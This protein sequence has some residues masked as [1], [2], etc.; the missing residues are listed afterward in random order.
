M[1]TALVAI[2]VVV[3][4]GLVACGGNGEAGKP[5]TLEQRLIREP[6]APGSREDPV[7][8]RLTAAN[9]DEFTAWQNEGYV[10]AAE[11][12][13]GKLKKAG[14]VAAIHDT[15]FFPKTLGGPHTRD[16]PHVRILV[17]QFGSEEGA[18]TGADLV[19][20]NGL[21]PCPG[22][23]AVQNEEFE[24]SGVPDAKGFR[25]FITAK[26]IQ[27]TGEGDEPF[28]S[29]TITFSDGAFV[30]EV[31]GFGPPG[32]ISKKQIEEIADTVYDRVKGAPPAA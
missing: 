10:R 16:A 31:E 30:Y 9:L 32:K 13:P 11:I 14:F 27:E 22:Q 24:P 3:L 23:C 6:E 29:Y 8:T 28:D 5:L 21:K 26:R 17:V 2:A 19:Y 12:D 7:E 1:R 15:R 20:T 25:R 18:A 4:T